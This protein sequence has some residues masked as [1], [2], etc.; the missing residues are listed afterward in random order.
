VSESGSQFVRW[1][2]KAGFVPSAEQNEEGEESW[3][4]GFRVTGGRKVSREVCR[5]VKNNGDAEGET[6]ERKGGGA[7]IAADFLKP[8][9]GG[10]TTSKEVLVEGRVT[11]RTG[12]FRR[13]RV[14]GKRPGTRDARFSV[15]SRTR[16]DTKLLMF[17]G[18]NV[19]KTLCCK[20][21]KRKALPVC[22][23]GMW[24]AIPEPGGTNK[25]HVTV[26]CPRRT[27]TVNY[28]KPGEKKKVRTCTD[29]ITPGVCVTIE[30][31]I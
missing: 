13:R 29:A 27:F 31:V 14:G 10:V 6:A 12:E 22:H 18:N 28:K 26:G 5:R 16:I 21:S 11:R 19:S 4:K 25:K 2:Q 9:T 17:S 8:G 24:G 3:G 30:V 1:A 20:P 23:R 15:S 7:D